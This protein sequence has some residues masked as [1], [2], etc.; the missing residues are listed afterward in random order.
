MQLIKDK[1][2]KSLNIL[3]E[4]VAQSRTKGPM[5]T[6]Q[7]GRTIISSEAQ[8]LRVAANGEPA[9]CSYIEALPA[10]QVL[11]LL[12]VI[13]F[14]FLRTVPL[15]ILTA[16]ISYQAPCLL[17]DGADLCI[18]GLE[19]AGVPFPASLLITP[20]S[21]GMPITVTGHLHSLALDYLRQSI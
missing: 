12:S 7:N 13:S 18:Y 17:E 1:R 5:F 11:Q 10:D 8:A 21:A 2:F 4:M 19:H 16:Q 15:S 3:N 6:I 14:S 20:L 9:V